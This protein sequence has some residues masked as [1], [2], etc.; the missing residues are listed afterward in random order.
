MGFWLSKGVDNLVVNP[1]AGTS[2]NITSFDRN[3]FNNNS[4]TTYSLNNTRYLESA[5]NKSFSCIVLE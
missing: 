2:I 3:S 5:Q 1:V 4:Q